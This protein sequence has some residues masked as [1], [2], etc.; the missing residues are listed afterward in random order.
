VASGNQ[1]PAPLTVAPTFELKRFAWATPDR[2]EL[3]GTFGGMQD[4]PADAAPVLVV[5]AGDLVHRLPAV[6]DSLNG[7]P[8]EGRVWQAQFAWQDAPVA[9][10][11]AELQ[12]GADRV[13]E[14]PE[15][16]AK[17]RLL[18]AQVLEVR[19]AQARGADD[20]RR[21]TMEIVRAP[22]SRAEATRERAVPEAETASV[23]SQ[24]EVIAAQEEV[25]EVRV[26]MQQTQA[27]LT[28]AREDLQAERERRAGDGERFRDG[29]AKV[30]ESAEK[31]LAAEQGTTQRLGTELREAH[32]AIEAKDAALETLRGQ[33]EAAAAAQTQAE[34]KAREEAEALR[35]HVAKLESDAKDTERLRAELERSRARADAART[36]LE[37]AYGS[38]DQARSD[39]ERVLGRLTA[40]RAK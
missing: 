22:R 30:R 2:L 20:A 8:E 32:E 7:P 14:L 23:G 31:A 33:L 40:I 17:R 10:D 4:V 16:G 21:E 25:R 37:K 29:L 5:R 24:V 12:L 15:P 13:V 26:A 38:V 36:E 28:R 27:E 1:T 34:A 35:K 11:V 18:R 9:F 19:T 39:A 3:S 6:P